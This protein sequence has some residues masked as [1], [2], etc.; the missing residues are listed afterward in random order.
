MNF[1]QIFWYIQ[2]SKETCLCFCDQF[3]TDDYIKLE[4]KLEESIFASFKSF[5]KTVGQFYSESSVNYWV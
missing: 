5:Q 2:V 1:G 4:L 3:E